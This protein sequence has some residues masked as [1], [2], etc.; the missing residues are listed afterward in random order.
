MLN[1]FYDS[2]RQRILELS[3]SAERALNAWS[4]ELKFS[5]QTIRLPRKIL[6]QARSCVKSLYHLTHT[7]EHLQKIQQ[8]LSPEDAWIFAPKASPSSALMAYDFHSNAEGELFLIEVNTNASSY[9]LSE[10]LYRTHG[11]SPAGAAADPRDQ[12]AKTFQL[13]FQSYALES[14][15]WSVAIVDDRPSEQGMYVE[16][17]MYQDLFL[18]MGWKAQIADIADLKW[19][20]NQLTSS[21][22]HFNGVYNRLTDFYFREPSTLPIKNAWQEGKIALTPHPREYALSSDK[23]RLYELARP[24]GLAPY[25]LSKEDHAQLRHCLIPSFLVEDFDS[26]DHIWQQR[27]GLF[28][29]PLSLFGGKSVYRGQS[30]SRKMFERV[31]SENPLI[32]K[33]IPAPQYEGDWKF[34]LRFFA[35]RDSIQLAVARLYKGQVTNFSTEGGGL[36]AIEFF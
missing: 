8:S 24:G 31:I 36:A 5:P 15:E 11:M 23:T 21:S 27:K 25:S 12:I 34:D 28:F 10:A 2:I 29:K 19:D 6:D 26:H 13:E 32:Q 7:P 1:S 22:A 9:L 3:P 14:P 33:Y 35:Y 4:L 20:R 18:Q 17:F 16:F 30:I